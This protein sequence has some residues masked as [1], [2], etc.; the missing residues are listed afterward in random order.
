MTQRGGRP[1]QSPF[2]QDK[3]VFARP[4]D[5]TGYGANDVIAATTDDTATTP[6]RSL[7]LATYPGRPFLLTKLRV[8]TNKDNFLPTLRVHFLRVSQPT[9]ALAGD[10]SGL[11]RA[12][13]NEDNYIDYV[14]LP[15]LQDVGDG[16]AARVQN[17]AVQ[18]TPAGVVGSESADDRVYYRIEI[19]STNS[20]ASPSSAQSFTI[21]AE[22]ADGSA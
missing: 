14:D 8:W 15:A 6:L 21:E 5:T 10:N 16:A 1:Y 17:I 22:G 19:T 18:L 12:Y 13:A 4:T 3:D 11:S 9:T 7:R 20:A 2:T